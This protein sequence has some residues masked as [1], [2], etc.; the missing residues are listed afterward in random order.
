MTNF[1]HITDEEKK[2][3]IIRGLY[4][5]S[6]GEVAVCPNAHCDNCVACDECK[7]YLGTD[8]KEAWL[9]AEYVAPKTANEKL[10]ETLKVGEVIA[11]SDNDENLT[12][13]YTYLRF[14][15][16]DAENDQIIT[17]GVYSWGWKYGR[18]LTANEKG[19]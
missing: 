16:Y 9:N 14:D 2:L 7:G 19:E 8:K 4:H 3:A 18:K 17:T 6:N 13:N 1:E 5:M 12:T 15:R 11:V 10:C